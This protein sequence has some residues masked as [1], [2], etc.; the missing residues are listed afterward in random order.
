M[1]FKALN[2]AYKKITLL[3]S[4]QSLQLSEVIAQDLNPDLIKPPPVGL[5]PKLKY[6]FNSQIISNELGRHL[7]FVNLPLLIVGIITIVAGITQ[8]D[9]VLLV[10]IV[11]FFIDTTFCL[12]QK[13]QIEA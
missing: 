5:F 9:L 7:F 6:V 4:V 12:L 8:F 13:V 11:I 3:P 10:V 1:H 2:L